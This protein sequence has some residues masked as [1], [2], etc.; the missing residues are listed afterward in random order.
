[1]NASSTY[2][3]LSIRHS[4]YRGKPGFLICGR[5]SI[6]RRLSIFCRNVI[7]QSQSRRQQLTLTAMKSI[8]CYAQKF[9]SRNKEFK[10]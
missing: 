9:P 2:H 10:E 6:G 4:V 5:D 3:T 1:M 7:P 8:A